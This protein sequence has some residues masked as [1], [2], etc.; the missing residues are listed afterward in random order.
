[1]VLAAGW[2][3][4]NAERKKQQLAASFADPL[5]ALIERKKMVET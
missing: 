5:L 3:E 2:V 1:M 4:G